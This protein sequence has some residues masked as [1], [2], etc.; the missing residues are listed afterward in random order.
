MVVCNICVHKT[1]DHSKIVNSS[2]IDIIVHFV[3]YKLL[4]LI[5]NS[6]QLIAIEMFE[7]DDI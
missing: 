2:H 1:W 3:E 6:S 5:R 7:N 4:E